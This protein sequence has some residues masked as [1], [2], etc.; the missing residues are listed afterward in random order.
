MGVFSIFCWSRNPGI[1]IV[2]IAI[3]IIGMRRIK[4]RRMLGIIISCH[5]RPFG[6]PSVALF[7]WFLVG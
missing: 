4:K 1:P 3:V 6:C 2:V 5:K 7:V